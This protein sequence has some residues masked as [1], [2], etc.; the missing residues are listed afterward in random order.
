MD[1]KKLCVCGIN[2]CQKSAGARQKNMEEKQMKTNK[3]YSLPIVFALMI[4]MLAGVAMAGTCVFDTP[5]ASAVLAGTANAIKINATTAPILNCTVT[6]ASTAS[7]G[8]FTVGTFSNITNVTANGS[9]STASGRDAS[10][11][12]FTATCKNSTGATIDTCTRTGLIIDNTVPVISGCTINGAAAA[13]GTV[14]SSD[15]TFACT[16]KNATTCNAYWKDSTALTYTTGTASRT[17]MSLSAFTASSSFGASG[18]AISAYLKS[19]ED[20]PKNAYIACTDGRNT[21]TGTTYAIST[22]GS[23]VAQK[24][25]KTNMQT[26]ATYYVGQRKDNGI[27][28]MIA[29]GAAVIFLLVAVLLIKKK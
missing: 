8:S 26:G 19:A 25:I 10:D 1:N 22:E 5:G 17:D 4:L 21:T 15:P 23:T 12:V 29:G 9:F 13:S 28:I 3:L 18:T 6:A 11:W 24:Q 16:I 7:G 2:S 20:T 27:A 14:G